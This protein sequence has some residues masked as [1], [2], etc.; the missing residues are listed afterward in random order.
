MLLPRNWEYGEIMCFST[1]D[2]PAQPFVIVFCWS[3]KRQDQM[4]ITFEVPPEN[5]HFFPKAGEPTRLT[6]KRHEFTEIHPF[7]MSSRG[8]PWSFSPAPGRGTYPQRRI[9]QRLPAGLPGWKLRVLQWW[10]LMMLFL[11][12][13]NLGIIIPQF[14]IM[15]WEKSGYTL[16]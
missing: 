16:W 9:S 1:T 3:S 5:D 13:E 15:G 12:W 10:N 14:G 6:L 4:I 8:I 11:Y 7:R 2:F